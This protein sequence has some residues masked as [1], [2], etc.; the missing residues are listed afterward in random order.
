MTGNKGEII[1][2]IGKE[3]ELNFIKFDAVPHPAYVMKNN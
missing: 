3:M 1:K 2:I